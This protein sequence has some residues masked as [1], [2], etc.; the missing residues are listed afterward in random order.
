MILGAVSI[1][2]TLLVLI[3]SWPLGLSSFTDVVNLVILILLFSFGCRIFYVD[4]KKYLKTKKDIET[5][6]NETKLLLDSNQVPTYPNAQLIQNK[7]ILKEV[8]QLIE[9]EKIKDAQ[10]IL[11]TDVAFYGAKL[12]FAFFAWLFKEDDQFSRY[13]MWRKTYKKIHQ[14]SYSVVKDLVDDS[15]EGHYLVDILQHKGKNISTGS[16]VLKKVNDTYT[17]EKL[18]IHMRFIQDD[19]YGHMIYDQAIDQ[20]PYTFN[21]NDILTKKEQHIKQTTNYF[22]DDKGMRYKK[23][24]M[25]KVK[26]LRIKLKNDESFDLVG[27]QLPF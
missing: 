20:K 24:S 4:L 13:H 11:N 10:A 21:V 7:R 16:Y 22:L 19:F 27:Y 2:F 1:I 14:A 3:F 6:L 25:Q 12:R 18:P 5:Y 15:K 17:L 9:N 23:D 8:I 26:C